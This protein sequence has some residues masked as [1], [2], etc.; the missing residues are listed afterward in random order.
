MAPPER[1]PSA[2][3]PAPERLPAWPKMGYNSSKLFVLPDK[4]VQLQHS[5]IREWNARF[6]CVA[7]AVAF[8]CA[9]FSDVACDAVVALVVALALDCVCAAASASAC[10]AEFAV[11]IAFMIAVV[12]IPSKRLKKHP[13]LNLSLSNRASLNQCNDSRVC[14]HKIIL[15]FCVFHFSCLDND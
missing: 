7:V 2:L 12:V 9:C 3:F 6:V 8:D 1:L 13:K 14:F 4:T 5:K 10:H 15:S 11:A